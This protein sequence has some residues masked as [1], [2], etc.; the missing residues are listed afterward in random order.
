MADDKKIPETSDEM[1]V[2][3]KAA[4]AG[5]D[6]V[7]ADQN[8]VGGAESSKQSAE[9]ERR[10]AAAAEQKRAELEYAEDYRRKLQRDKKRADAE[11]REAREAEER[12]AR[13]ARSKEI[14]ETLEKDRLEAATRGE[15]AQAILDR[16]IAARELRARE[17]S[18]AVQETEDAAPS[19]LVTPTVDEAEETEMP[20]EVSVN[21]EEDMSELVSEAEENTDVGETVEEVEE[22]ESV[23]ETEC[24]GAKLI[25]NIL[26]DRIVLDITETGATVSGPSVSGV[27]IHEVTPSEVLERDGTALSVKQNIT[28]STDD[29]DDN[30]ASADEIVD[31]KNPEYDDPIT[32]ENPDVAAIKLLGRSISTKS[33]FRKYINESKSTVKDLNKQIETYENALLIDNIAADCIASTLVEMLRAVGAVVEI[34][35]DNLR[36]VSKFAQRRY[37]PE[38][39]KLLSKDIDRYNDKVTEFA[40]RTGERLTR[41]SSAL[42]DRIAEGTGA[43]IIPAFSYR[44]KYVEMREGENGENRETV[45]I[46]LPGKGENTVIPA[47]VPES[48]KNTIRIYTITPVYPSVSASEF[49]Y[50]EHVTD[51]KSYKNYLKSASYADRKINAEINKLSAGINRAKERGED[52]DK[53]LN[54][55]RA[56]LD[57]LLETVDHSI[58]TL[59]DKK[60]RALSPIEKEREKCENIEKKIEL[61]RTYIDG[62]RSNAEIVIG[63]LALEREKLVIC[64]NTLVAAKET[65]SNKLIVSAKNR[66]ISGMLRYNKAIDECSRYIDVEFTPV[67]ADLADAILAGKSD[68]KI[69]EIALLRELVEKVGNDKRVVGPRAAKAAAGA[70]T[71]SINGPTGGQRRFAGQPPIRTV[72]GR[73]FMGGVA[74]GNIAGIQQHSAAETAASAAIAVPVATA[75]ESIPVN[76]D[77]VA[78]SAAAGVTAIG[79]VEAYD[80]P[81]VVETVSSVE[82][83]EAYEAPIVYQLGDEPVTAEPELESVNEIVEAVPAAAED[84]TIVE[85]P[86]YTEEPV[87]EEAPVFEEEPVTEEIPVFEEE[88][89]AEEVPI[90]EEQSVVEETPVFEEPVADE[91][92]VV[93]EEQ[94][95]AEEEAP[96]AESQPRIIR[97]RV[98]D[99]GGVE[100]IIEEPYPE[101]LVEDELGDISDE[102][103]VYEDGVIDEP[104]AEEVSDTQIPDFTSAPERELNVNEGEEDTK[105]KKKVKLVQLP[106]PEQSEQ[107]A[108]EL[109]PVTDDG[110]IYPGNSVNR[111]Y[112]DEDDFDPKDSTK[113]PSVIE[114]D[115]GAEDIENDILL[116]PTK[117][118]LRKHLSRVNSR[119]RKAMRERRKLLAEKRRT[120]G[121]AGKAR[122]YVEILGVQKRII[123]WYI[124]AETS[125]CDLG[126]TRRARRIANALRSELKRY[127]RYVKEYEKLTGDRLTEASL[128][129]PKLI[130]E[131]EDYQMLPKVKIRQFE[132]PED[133]VVYG[134]GVTENA[135][136]VAEYDSDVVMTE[137]DLNKRLNES[138]R[139]ISKLHGELEDKQAEKHNAWGIDRTIYTVECFGIQKKII[140]TLASDLRCA[141]Q[142]SSVK[143]I[144]SLKKELSSEIKAYNK[145]VTDYK[146]SSGN[147]L[148]MASENIAQD[149]IAGNLYIPIPRVGCIYINEDEDL[150]NDLRAM[151]RNSYGV[152]DGSS[153]GGV[154]FRTKVTSQANKDLSLVTKRADYQI[155][156]LESERDILAYRYGKDPADV[157]REKREIAKRIK[158]IRASHK[159]ALGYEN[160]DNRRYYAAV[161]SNPYTMELKNKRAD[162]ARVALLRSKIIDL[163]N[164]RDIVN[165][166]LIALYTGAEGTFGNESINQEWRRVKTR[167]AAKAKNKQKQLAEAVKHL[168]ITVAE[169]TKV[170]SMMNEKI[171]AESTLALTKYRLKNEDL[172]KEDKQCAKNDIKETRAKI[173][174]IEKRI[175]DRMKEIKDRIS[176]MEATTSWFRSFIILLVIAVIGLLLYFYYIGPY[177][178]SLLS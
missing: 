105:K 166:K 22:T 152:E 49:L 73:F 158:S 71:I 28:V 177:I 63:C 13:E 26:D 170:Y 25:L 40:T 123:D 157:K 173:R 103:I 127:N 130:L 14:A 52:L 8:K 107:A 30:K 122:V 126:A 57:K 21:T 29:G 165:G 85:E 125:C 147:S 39:K 132:A 75:S 124:N 134:D 83:P 74:V 175:N 120:E 151:S 121:I 139:Q 31:A 96:I 156:M 77:V 99:E 18:V 19:S 133:G 64:L 16:V 108:E 142:V 37:I 66:L 101:K 162:R 149:I 3:A 41:L 114:V 98:F 117:R 56:V 7:N 81:E 24:D 111:E 145:L 82:E 168:P 176:D 144:Q 88:P 135:D 150:E 110:P 97:R 161:T 46:N 69:P 1:S 68:A 163:L 84:A 174:E 91:A 11:A 33:A 10:A 9:K 67:T 172:H 138:M 50:G 118:G 115:D 32:S 15:R 44:E 95:I 109:R 94:I 59:R 112:I 137:K 129:I 60:D 27:N 17:A 47:A 65:S 43:E 106:P 154:A 80:E 136:Y 148:T 36:I 90:F 55:R 87:I 6:T 119:I 54:R 116:K 178:V 92:P 76:S 61:N 169:K 2:G 72:H 86:V 113:I 48:A 78:V 143:K 153:V 140:D 51:E 146:N 131:G 23:S 89:I 164:E 102:P 53:K 34:R 5:I 4:E 58:E 20:A 141:C 128:D 12:A 79:A 62:Q 155:S 167:A 35:C 171:D 70:Y 42:V 159:T 45:V 100:D 93:E 104:V 38:I 160:N